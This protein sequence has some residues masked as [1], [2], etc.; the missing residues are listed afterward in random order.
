MEATSKQW[1]ERYSRRLND[2]Q[3]D[4]SKLSSDERQHLR[5]LLQEFELEQRLV[6]IQDKLSQGELLLVEA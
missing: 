6:G 4:L 1:V 5:M 3:G 2:S